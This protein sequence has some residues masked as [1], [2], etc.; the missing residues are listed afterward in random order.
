[1]SKTESCLTPVYVVKCRN[2]N[3]IQTHTQQKKIIHILRSEKKPR[4]SPN[5]LL[6]I[7]LTLTLLRFAQHHRPGSNMVTLEQMTKSNCDGCIRLQAFI[8]KSHLVFLLFLIIFP[9]HVN[10]LSR[11]LSCPWLFSPVSPLAQRLNTPCPAL[12]FQ[13]IAFVGAFVCTWHV[14]AFSRS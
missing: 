2:K 4:G 14:L 9:P 1:M 7:V 10:H 13:F 12:S 5:V 8:L 11:C 3:Q 6:L